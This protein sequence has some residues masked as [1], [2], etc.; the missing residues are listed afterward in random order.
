MQV[1]L[2]ISNSTNNNSTGPYGI[3]I[4][5]LK[6]LGLLTIRYLTNM[7][8]I[9]LNTSTL[10]HLW[11]R[12]TVFPISKPNKDHNICTNYLPI[13]L[14]SPIA[15]TL[16]KTLLPYITE[17]ILAISHQHG[18]KQKHS[19]QIASDNVCHQ[20]TKGFNTK[21]PPPRMVIVALHM[22][23]AFDTVNKHKFIHKIT[24]TNISNNIIKFIGNYMKGR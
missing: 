24:L 2:A 9:T 13:T 6:Q 15:K 11:K 12:A 18:F 22:S 20:I 19:T 8:N 23:K 7:Y 3:N 17:N 10:P 1:Q 16:E 14:L 4:I 21:R 5:H